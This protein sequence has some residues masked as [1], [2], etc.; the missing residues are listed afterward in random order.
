MLLPVQPCGQKRGIKSVNT[1]QSFWK[2]SSEGI[3]FYFYELLE[4]FLKGEIKT[5]NF[6][7]VY[8]WDGCHNAAH[9]FCEC[10]CAKFL[11]NIIKKMLFI[12]QTLYLY[13]IVQVIYCICFV[14][15]QRRVF[16]AAS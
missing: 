6:F 7:N 5:H 8:Q 11:W 14:H 15:L 1:V 16:I 3:I 13:R 9:L 2:S 10:S 4:C 12:W